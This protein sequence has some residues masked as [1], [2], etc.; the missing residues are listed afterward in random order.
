M[1]TAFKISFKIKTKEAAVKIK[2]TIDLNLPQFKFQ[3]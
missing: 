3:F 2:N 1:I